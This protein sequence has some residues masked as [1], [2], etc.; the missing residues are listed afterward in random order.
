MVNGELEV[1]GVVVVSVGATE[2]N[3]PAGRVGAAP[4]TATELLVVGANVSAGSVGAALNG[5]AVDNFCGA[6]FD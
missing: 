4:R 1:P 3:T 5:G 2:L 6:G